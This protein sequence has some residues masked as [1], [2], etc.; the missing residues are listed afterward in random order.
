[1]GFFSALTF[2][3]KPQD[4]AREM[5]SSEEFRAEIVRRVNSRVDIP[6]LNEDQEAIIIANVVGVCL[7]EASRRLFMGGYSRTLGSFFNS[8]SVL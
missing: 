7:D 8:R 6:D 2:V 1:M 5:L 4:I 3:R